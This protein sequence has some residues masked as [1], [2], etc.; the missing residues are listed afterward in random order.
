MST[1]AKTSHLNHQTIAKRIEESLDAIGIL[2][3]VLLKNGGRKGDPEDVDTSDPIDDR[4]ESG[5]QS[6]ISIIACLA[7]RDFCELAT[8]PGIPE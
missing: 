6:A 7:H 5:I 4:G 8:D 3:E 1:K 2:A